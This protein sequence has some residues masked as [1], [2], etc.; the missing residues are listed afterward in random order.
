[1]NTS[2]V[3]HLRISDRSLTFICRKTSIPRKEPK[4]VNTRQFKH[5]NI[6]AFCSD[7]GK[8]L[9]IQ[10]ADLLDPNALWEEWKNKFVFIANM[11]A[12]QITKKVRSMPLGLQILSRKV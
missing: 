1:M 11:H 2:G 10:S 12:P 8:T 5:Y 4:L 7:L 3:E 6:N 9:Q